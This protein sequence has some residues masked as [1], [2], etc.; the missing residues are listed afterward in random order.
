ML[1]S[2]QTI[3][4]EPSY[5]K[6]VRQIILRSGSYQIL[7]LNKILE[8]LDVLK[9]NYEFHPVDCT[10]ILLDKTENLDYNLFL[11]LMNLLSNLTREIEIIF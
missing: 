8:T 4:N 1:Y 9:I 3:M 7:N 2:K 10:V 11:N 5:Y 6:N